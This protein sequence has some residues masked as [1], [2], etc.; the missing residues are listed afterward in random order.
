MERE[1]VLV[2]TGDDPELQFA[3]GCHA[4]AQELGLLT[5]KAVLPHASHFAP[6]TPQG[7]FRRPRFRQGERGVS[8]HPVE[9]A[10]R[11]IRGR[12]SRRLTPDESAEAAR[13]S[14]ASVT[15]LESRLSRHLLDYEAGHVSAKEWGDRCF[16]DISHFYDLSYRSGLNAAGDPGVLLSPTQ[17]AV[18]N[19]LK[20]DEHDYLRD[21]GEDM[22]AGRGRMPYHDRMRLYAQAAREA[23]WVGF[24]MG[25]LRTARQLR[26]VLGPT[27]HCVDCR[28]FSQ[29]GWVPA[30]RFYD[31]VLSKGYVPQ[32]GHLDCKG[33]RCQC[34]LSEQVNGSVSTPA[35]V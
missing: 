3:Q 4:L 28:R 11:D 22:N 26:W 24:V 30:R 16:E 15:S 25:D 9:A 6:R 34:V 2:I 23:F 12:F 10:V 21:F 19:R 27:E 29:M 18:L 5:E 35:V 8:L 31:E 13:Q 32:S 20:R 33:S 1:L 7:R 14:R 17:R